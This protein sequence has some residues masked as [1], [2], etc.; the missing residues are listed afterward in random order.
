MRRS[1]MAPVSRLLTVVL[2]VAMPLAV[3]SSAAQVP[4]P[5]PIQPAQPRDVAP[6]AK[7]TAAIVG[8]VRISR[9]AGR[10]GEP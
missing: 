1:T 7:G 8:R 10:C 3:R 6:A 4:S 2:V 5:P 9:R